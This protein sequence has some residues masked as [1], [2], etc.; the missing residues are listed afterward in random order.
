[1]AYYPGDSEE[2][3]WLQ[4]GIITF[5]FLLVAG[6]FVVYFSPDVENDEGE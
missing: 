4:A 5:L 3:L 6:P 1:M 2:S